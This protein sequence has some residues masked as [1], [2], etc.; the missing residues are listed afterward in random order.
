MTPEVWRAMELDPVT[1]SVN[2]DGKIGQD[3]YD[4]PRSRADA[5]QPRA[6]RGSDPNETLA[7]ADDV[8]PPQVAPLQ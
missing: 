7:T 8:Q 4:N 6:W 2:R 5:F 1:F 3:D